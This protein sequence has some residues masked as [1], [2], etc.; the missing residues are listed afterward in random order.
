M[1]LILMLV[2]RVGSLDIVVW[3]SLREAGQDPYSDVRV[4]D[5]LGSP[6]NWPSLTPAGVEP[7]IDPEEELHR[8]HV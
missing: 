8:T 2:K 7:D 5:E 1:A 6:T 4:S 3:Q